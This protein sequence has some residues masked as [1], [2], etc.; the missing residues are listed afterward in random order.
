MTILQIITA[1]L[2]IIKLCP[3]NTLFESFCQE[4]LFFYKGFSGFFGENK[5]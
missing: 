2:Q 5:A 1:H 4:W 3:E